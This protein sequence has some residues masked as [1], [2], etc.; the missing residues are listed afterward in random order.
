MPEDVQAT[1]EAAQTP[2]EKPKRTWSRRPPSEDPFEGVDSDLKA[3][4]IISRE[5]NGLRHESPKR[6]ALWFYHRYVKRYLEGGQAPPE[7][8][9]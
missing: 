5:M 2:A 1:P 7:P 8:Q 3:Q 4:M 6:V 9:A